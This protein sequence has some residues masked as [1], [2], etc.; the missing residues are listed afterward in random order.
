[1]RINFFGHR[2][3]A[4]VKYLE[5]AFFCSEDDVAIAGNEKTTETVTTLNGSY[6]GLKDKRRELH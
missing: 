1:M 5:A 2:C 4:D 3:R 6:T